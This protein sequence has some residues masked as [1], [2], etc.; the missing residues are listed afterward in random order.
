MSHFRATLPLYIVWMLTAAFRRQKTWKPIR[1][2]RLHITRLMLMQT[3]ALRTNIIRRNNFWIIF[4][5]QISYHVLLCLIKLH[6]RKRCCSSATRVLSFVLS[7]AT[8]KWTSV[9]LLTS[10]AS[11]NIKP[12]PCE[13]SF[14]KWDAPANGASDASCFLY[15][16]SSLSVGHVAHCQFSMK[17]T[18]DIFRVLFECKRFLL[19]WSVDGCLFF[20]DRVRCMVPSNKAQYR[21]RPPYITLTNTLFATCTRA[22]EY[23]LVELTVVKEFTSIWNA[24]SFL[25]HHPSQQH[26]LASTSMQI[27]A[28]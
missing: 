20:L 13:L 10:A 27:A 19:S 15:D 28:D 16:I 5:P 17:L 9:G 14:T 21:S 18:K 26:T 22:N 3:D 8:A 1:L 12:R 24:S 4:I 25:A 7:I 6:F 23:W 2:R 11:N